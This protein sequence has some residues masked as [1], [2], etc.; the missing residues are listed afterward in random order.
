MSP[1]VARLL[2]FGA[3]G[4]A[5]GLL[6]LLVLAVVGLRGDAWAGMDATSRVITW[7]SLA[8]VILA[9]VGVHVMIGLRLLRVAAGKRERA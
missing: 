5:V 9:L 7:I 3:L 8:G 2:G 6:A 1:K 4:A